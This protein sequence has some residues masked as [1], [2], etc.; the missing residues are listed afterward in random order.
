MKNSPELPK[1]A[2]F[3]ITIKLFFPH[4]K[5]NALTKYPII[6]VFKYYPPYITL[7]PLLQHSKWK[8]FFYVFLLT[9]L[10]FYDQNDF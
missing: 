9:S 1:K 5:L 7:Y 8:S 6:C 4:N 10:K 3:C 2:H